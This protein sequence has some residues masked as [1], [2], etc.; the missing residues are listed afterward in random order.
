MKLITSS[1]THIACPRSINPFYIVSNYIKW[2][3]TSW[4]YSIMYDVFVVPYMIRTQTFKSKWYVLKSFL[5]N[6]ENKRNLAKYPITMRV[7]V[8]ANLDL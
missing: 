4:T 5:I 2:V 3:T 8:S 7:K 1:W 6:M